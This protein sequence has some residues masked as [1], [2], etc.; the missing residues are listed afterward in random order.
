[1]TRSIK[2]MPTPAGIGIGQTASVNLPLG[3]TYNTFFIRMKGAIGGG[4]VADVAEADWGTFIDEIRLLVDGDSTY[5][6]SAADLVKLNR[7]YGQVL[8]NGTLPIHLS[9]PWMRT[10]GG[11]DQ[12]SYGTAGG[13]ASF[14]LEMD[15]KTGIT[16][17]DLDVYAVQSPGRPFGTHLRLQRF[18]HNQGITGDAEISDIPRGPYAMAALHFNTADIEDVEVHVDNRKV[19]DTDLAIRAAQA[20]VIGRSPQAGMT[21]VD[22]L[23]ENRLVEAMPMA[24]SDFR[25]KANF[26]A[27][28]NF[29]I[30]AESIRGP[31]A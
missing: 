9:R 1:M 27:T 26:T 17:N 30:Y 31:L 8:V 25:V 29:N 10:I 19:I 14:S 20:A 24:V 13:L 2:R 22:F 15:L 6:I 21:H 12:T 5:Q 18:V 3:L 23:T 11:E 16:V 7:F 4:A 28:G